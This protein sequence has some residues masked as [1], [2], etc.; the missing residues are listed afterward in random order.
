[1]YIFSKATYLDCFKGNLGRRLATGCSLQALQQLTGVNFIFYYGTSFFKH[2][3]IKNSFTVSMITYGLPLLAQISPRNANSVPS[4]RSAV[5]V[6]STFPGLYMV[7]SWGRRPLLLFG[8][9][10]MAVCQF[11]VAGVG[12]GVGITD[13]AGQ[14]A[15]IAFV[16]IYIFFFACS[17]GP[18]E[19][20][21]ISKATYVAILTLRS[22]CL[23][24]HR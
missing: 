13:Q 3:G 7:E 5:N 14:Q 21:Q 10:G 17:W 1:M 11:I 23:G 24:G 18:C 15:L 8:A 19:Y 2:S 16:C 4:S 22:R 20:L 9:A 6:G 12:T